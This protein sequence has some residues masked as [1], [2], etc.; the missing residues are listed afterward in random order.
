METLILILLI[1]IFAAIATVG[2]RLL[3]QKQSASS[4][5]QVQTIIELN[6][7]IAAR[8]QQIETLQEQSAKQEEKLRIQFENLATKILDETSKKF[9]EQNKG[10]LK[11]I[12]EPLGVRI[13]D[14]EKKVSETYIQGTKER[15]TLAQQIKN[16][17]E[18]NIKISEDAVN[19]TKAL[20]GDSKIQG[21]WGEFKLE[22]ILE[23]AGL[24]NG[25]HYSTQGSFQD[26]EGK[27]K[28]PDVIINLPEAKCLIIDSKVSLTA[29]TNYYQSEDEEEKERHLKEH[30]ASVRR[31]VQDL[32]SKNYQK[33]Y[34]INSPDYVLMFVPIEPAFM[35]A[36][37]AD[38]DL[39]AWAVEKKNIVIVPTSTLLA[40]ISMVSSI[41]KQEDQKKNVLEIARQGGA[42]YDKFVGFVEDL[43]GVGK[44][45][46]DAKK[47]YDGAMNKLS[48]G[49]DNLVR[50][51]ENIKLLGVKTSK[52]LPETLLQRAVTDENVGSVQ[53]DKPEEE[54]IE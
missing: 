11:D 27:H 13:K 20:K 26:E 8:D 36:I 28:R 29:Y 23:K 21:D 34:Q 10:N 25:L 47:S 53:I 42:L 32:S 50:K 45:L 30:V 1:L 38:P 46:N 9:T 16:L 5:D 49:K 37:Q 15:S 19:L 48:T 12:L 22:M 31:H 44:K 33:L 51:T 43:I 4:G 17:S 3:N 40:T 41:W 14:F 24:T 7:E 2:Y 54:G 52:S 35:L 6:R 39:M 18:L